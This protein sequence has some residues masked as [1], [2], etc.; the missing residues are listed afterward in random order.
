M[1]MAKAGVLC[2]ESTTWSRHWCSCSHQRSGPALS[3]QRLMQQHPNIELITQSKHKQHSRSPKRCDL[4]ELKMTWRCFSWHGCLNRLRISGQLIAA[5]K[6]HE[7]F[8]IP[9]GWYNWK[10]VEA[11]ARNLW[12]SFKQIL[13]QGSVECMFRNDLPAQDLIFGGQ[14][15][16][17]RRIESLDS[18]H[19]SAFVLRSFK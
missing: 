10:E 12:P 5:F 8:L 14:E 19:N 11:P 15:Y 1:K 6:H 17:E 9:F 7:H 2:K 18:D 16:L 13:V 4:K 3:S